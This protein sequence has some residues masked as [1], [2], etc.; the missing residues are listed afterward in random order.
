MYTNL[1]KPEK[2]NHLHLGFHFT[3][4]LMIF[5]EAFLKSLRV[6][7]D[8][9]QETKFTIFPG[10]PGKPAKPTGPLKA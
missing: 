7:Y 9:S 10:K 3:L 4:P 2:C 1:D 5:K 8:R 6:R